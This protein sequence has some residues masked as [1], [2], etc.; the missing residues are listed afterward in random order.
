MQFSAKLD[1]FYNDLWGF[2]FVVPKEIA[3]SF[4]Q[5]DDRRVIATF[6][7]EIKNHCAL[8]PKKGEYFILIN[9][10]TREKLKIT[11]GDSVLISLEKDTSEYGMPMPE[12]M[13]MVLSQDEDSFRIFEGLTP[14]KK[15]TLIFLVSSVKNIDSRIRKSLAIAEHLKLCNGKIDFKQLN[16]LIK[17]YNQSG[18]F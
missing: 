16:E 1:Q 8:M 10:Q 2:H 17:M 6:N 11:V 5:E 14:G 7:D 15:R 3:L 12:E 9:K 13:L 18:R 4:I